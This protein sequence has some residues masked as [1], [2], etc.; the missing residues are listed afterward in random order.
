VTTICDE[1]EVWENWYKPIVNNVTDFNNEESILFETFG[2]EFE[3][4]LQCPVKNVWTWVD[5]SDGTYILSGLHFVNRIGYF[6][7]EEEWQ[8]PMVIAYEKY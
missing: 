1:V 3:R 4:V 6:I 7:T 2:A 8:S 5:G